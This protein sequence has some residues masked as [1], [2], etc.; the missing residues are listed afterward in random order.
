MPIGELL[1]FD[2]SGSLMAV[3][4]DRKNPRA[5]EDI[6][7]LPP[8]RLAQSILAKERRIAEILLKIK[9]LRDQ[10]K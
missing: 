7:H 2:P 9:C 1:Q 4:L 3:N 10:P 6:T 8:E 5:K